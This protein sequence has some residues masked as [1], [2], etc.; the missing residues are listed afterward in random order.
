MALHVKSWPGINTGGSGQ[1]YR[2]KYGAVRVRFCIPC[3]RITETKQCPECKEKVSTFDSTAE[4]RRYRELRLLEKLGKISCLETQPRFPLVV[5]GIL[6]STYYADFRYKEE[7]GR[8]VVEDV[9]GVR[10][11][12]YKIKRALMKAIYGINVLET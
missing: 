5:N 8:E 3:E 6:I 1:R 4:Y 10:T 11:D 2:N 9:K 12:L 7:D